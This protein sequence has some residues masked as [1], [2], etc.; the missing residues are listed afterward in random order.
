V[1]PTRRN[2]R[3]GLRSSALRGY[4]CLSRCPDKWPP[5][6]S[7]CSAP[8]APRSSCAH[9]RAARSP[10]LLLQRRPPPRQRDA[11]RLGSLT[12]TRTPTTPPRII[13]DGPEIWRQ[14]EGRSLTYVT[15]I[16]TAARSR[17]GTLGR[18]VAT[19]RKC[20]G[21]GEIIGAD[22]EAPF[23]SGGS[24]APTWWKASEKISGLP[25]STEHR[26]RGHRDQRRRLLRD[27]KAA[28]PRGRPARRRLV[29]S[30]RGRGAARLR[31][32]GAGRRH[33]RPSS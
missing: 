18:G 30:R 7:P 15:G 22:P 13:T 24:G 12:S 19:S 33:R 3:G 32:G 21:Q 29:R 27:D 6:R 20:R 4:R 11:E 10:G 9:E 31:H 2:T 28:R 1:E 5:T 17:G 25:P 16:V 26:R 8:T 14:T 23:Y